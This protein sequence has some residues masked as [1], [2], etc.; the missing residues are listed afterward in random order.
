MDVRGRVIESVQVLRRHEPQDGYSGCFSGGKDSVLLY[1]MAK[2]AG[3]KVQWHYANT[4]IDPPELVYFMREHYPDVAWT[5]SKYG[6]LLKRAVHKGLLPTRRSRWCCQ[7]YKELK[8]PDGTTA[9]I[10]IRAEESARRQKSWNHLEWHYKN[11]HWVVSPL[12]NW[13]S[14]ELWAYL[15]AEG[16]PT[17]SLYREGFH[18]LG[19][20]GCPLASPGQRRREFERW[21]NFEKAWRRASKRMWANKAGTM[22][23]SG[24][25]WGPSRV[26]RSEPEYW[27]WWMS[28]RTWPGIMGFDRKEVGR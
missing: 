14:D 27:D 4:T 12:Y 7:E 21:P 17:C 5:R 15:N 13:A 2:L 8:P 24:M 19:C 3:V 10:G 18:R 28:G 26:F 11:K 9:L 20:V 22:M 25:E 6:P 1:S 23:R 16:I